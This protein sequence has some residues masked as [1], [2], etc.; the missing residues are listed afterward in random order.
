MTTFCVLRAPGTNCDIETKY[1][2]E[3]FGCDAEVVHINRFLEDKKDLS[4]Y[5]GLVIP[6]GFS[7]GDHV[8]SG[9]ILGKIVAKKLGSA[10][11]KMAGD[12]KPVLGICN[13]FQV[14]VESGILPGFDAGKL[15]TQAAL[16]TNTSSKYE[17]RWTYLKNENEGNCIFTEEVKDITRMPIA[18]GEGKFILPR[19]SEAEYLAHLKENDQIAFCYATERGELADGVYPDN[20]N[21]SLADIA[22]ICDAS[23]VVMGMMPHPERAFFRITYPDWTRNPGEDIGDGYAIFKNMVQYAKKV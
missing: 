15:K 21:G 19:E 22:G 17:D 13:G 3:H 7:F 2:L 20:P 14:L 12:E 5:S 16:G 8:R 6:G 10:V 23:G 18:H 11:M 9:A 4:K 1:S